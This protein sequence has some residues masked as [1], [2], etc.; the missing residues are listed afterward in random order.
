MVNIV[1]NMINWV[2]VMQIF[3]AAMM[4][5]IVTNSKYYYDEQAM[6]EDIQRCERKKKILNV[7]YYSLS[8]FLTIELII[9]GVLQRNYKLDIYCTMAQLEVELIPGIFIITT[10]IYSVKL[11]N[12]TL[13]LSDTEQIQLNT[14]QVLL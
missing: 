2:Y 4:F 14:S 5:Q 1:Y 9:L 12:K 8:A 3:H 6:L 10:F 13:K 7:I 11:I